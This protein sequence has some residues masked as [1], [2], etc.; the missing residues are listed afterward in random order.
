[1]AQEQGQRQVKASV[2]PLPELISRIL[3]VIAGILTLILLAGTFYALV[4]RGKSE[5]PGTVVAAQSEPLPLETEID[6]MFTGIGRIRAS[7]GSPEPAMVILSIAFPYSPRDRAFSEELA[8]RIG[9]FRAG[10]IG[11][12]A[13]FSTEELRQKDEAAIKKELLGRF[14][15]LLRLGQITTLYFSDYLIIE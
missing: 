1:M 7:T 12:F 3:A 11:Y 2:L 13:S 4:L 6:S 8:A 14:N 15:K 10:A 9:D 5:K